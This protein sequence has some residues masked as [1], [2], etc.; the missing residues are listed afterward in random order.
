MVFAME[1]RDLESIKLKSPS[2]E[3]RQERKHIKNITSHFS[4]NPIEEQDD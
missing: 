2:I 4:D 1:A 3:T